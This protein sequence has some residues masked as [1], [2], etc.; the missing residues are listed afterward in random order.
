[1]FSA[2]KK[3]LSRGRSVDS[4]KDAIGQDQDGGAIK[5]HSDNEGM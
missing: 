4:E 2:R 1:M 3:R 5:Y